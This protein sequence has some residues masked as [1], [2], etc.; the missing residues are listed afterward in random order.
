MGR[1]WLEAALEGGLLPC[2]ELGLLGLGCPVS[3]E[4]PVCI[5]EERYLSPVIFL[6][7]QKNRGGK[8]NPGL[9]VSFP[10]M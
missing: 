2:L 4:G 10:C 7:A 6:S 3:L 1:G 8:E 9:Q 5:E